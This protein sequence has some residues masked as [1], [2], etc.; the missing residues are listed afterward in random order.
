VSPLLSRIEVNS[1]LCAGKPCIRGTRILVSVILDALGEGLTPEAVVVQH[2]P[3]TTEDVRA[4]IA[5]AAKVIR[6]EETTVL[7]VSG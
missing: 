4:A 7:R 5:Y 2:P 1:K 6:E 3:L